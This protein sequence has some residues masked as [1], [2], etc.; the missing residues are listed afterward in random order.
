MTGP[1]VGPPDHLVPHSHTG[2][3]GTD[4]GDHAG[5]VGALTGGKGRG[6]TFV[7]H[8]L[9]DRYLT[10]IDPAARTFTNT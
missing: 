2:D 3:S 9:A 10:G 6:P 1:V 5:E 7:E 8:T 4:I